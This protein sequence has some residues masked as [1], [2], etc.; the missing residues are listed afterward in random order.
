MKKTK[1]ICTIGEDTSNEEILKE[2]ILNGMDVARMSFSTCTHE[3]IEKV[4]KKIKKLN[5]ELNKNVGILLDTKGPGIRIINIKESI[6]LESDD[7]I[8]LSPN[9]IGKNIINITEKKL[10]LSLDIDDI[11]LLNDGEI[12]LKVI[13]I[14]NADILCKVLKGGIPKN[15][16]NIIIP[17][18]ELDLDYLTMTDKNDIL[19][20]SKLNVEFISLSFIKNANDVLDVNDLLIGERNEHTGIISKIENQSSINDIENIVKVSDGV[21][22]A[23]GDLGTT[24]PFER[25]PIIQKRIIK[26]ARRRNKISIISTEM[27]SSMID[28]KIPSKSEVSDISNAVMDGVDA[29]VLCDETSIG[30]YPILS[31]KT[32]CKI[33]EESE[34]GFDYN[35]ILLE[36]KDEKNIDSTTV[37]SYSAVDVSNMINAKAIAV[38]TSSG[39][40][41]KRIS[42]F[43][44]NSIVVV[45]T[46]DEEVAKS[47]SLNYGIIPIVVNQFSSMEDII[48][49]SKEEVGKLIKLE[50]DDKIVI[51]GGFP[52]KKARST[53]F[54]KIEEIS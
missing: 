32:M 16:T 48:E 37:L 30:S 15:N 41:A 8:T 5:K 23:R 35:N 31:I 46:T 21:I 4:V 50:S 47:L 45:L 22:L 34:K 10:S 3:F 14:S 26:E 52:I 49:T 1:I 24:I 43:R 38:S 54:I 13:G 18:V 36:K 9:K 19:F 25:L 7:I 6:E 28:K 39:Y 11:L 42:N 27:L 44:P 2:M 20:A 17:N 51:T 53:N 29:L 33:I 40:T 12:E